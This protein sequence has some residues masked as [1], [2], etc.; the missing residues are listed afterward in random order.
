MSIRVLFV[1]ALSSLHAGTG[2]GVGVIDLPIARERATD[3]PLIP[4]S[5]IKGCLREK[6]RGYEDL[7][8]KEDSAG[9]LQVSDARL[10]LLPVRCLGASFVWTTSSYVLRRLQR[11]LQS[12]GMDAGIPPIPE[13][14][15]S[16]ASVASGD[17][18][19]EV[20]REKK[21]VLEEL[22]FSAKVE[23]AAWSDWIGRR[24]FPNTSGSNP[25]EW[26]RELNKRFAILDDKS[27]HHLARFATEVNAHVRIDQKKGTV[28]TG[29]LW[30][31]E[32]LPAET[33]LISLLRTETRRG[34]GVDPEAMLQPILQEQIL[35]IGGK[36]TTGQG[37]VRLI[38]AGG[39]Q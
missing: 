37:L 20:N 26:H 1:H 8:G 24:L 3:L 19:V 4:G 7:F 34:S 27:F 29:G 17:P 11:D 22:D 2:Q 32:S 31:Q 38:P 6:Y 33:V 35:Q 25:S 10:L 28:E 14:A 21:L 23:G 15:D 9:L 12:A 5:S 13:L 18:L 39:A 30:Y 16:Q 36:A